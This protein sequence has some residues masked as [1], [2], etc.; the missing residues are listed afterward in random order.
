MGDRTLDIGGV[1]M[2]F[3]S[4]HAELDDVVTRR[5][6]GFLSTERPDWTFHVDLRPGGLVPGEDVCVRA[7]GG[8]G[9]FEIERY[10]FTAQVDLRR[11]VGALALADFDEI[12]VDSFL[13][14]AYSLA[15]LDAGGLLV[16]AASL[17]RDGAAFLFPGRSGS[18][19]TTVSRLSPPGA[20][21]SDEISL[22][23]VGGPGTRCYGTPF[24]GDLQR[25]GANRTAPLAG[26]HFLRQADHHARR[27][28]AAGD[29]LR[30][31]LPNVVFFARDDAL[32]ARVL[33][34]AGALVEDRPRFELS[35]RRDPGFWE[36]VLH[37]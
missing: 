10:D 3:R 13:R 14:V 16:H 36:A 32:A 34:I 4:R 15:L 27:P 35:F 29:A 17:V 19:K 1:R 20:L 22:V 8:P 11:R 6:P 21:L 24:W 30:R 5:Y 12:G 31:L 2:A 9:R 28:L 33:A 25:A 26:I 7:D 37:E 18:G 23:R